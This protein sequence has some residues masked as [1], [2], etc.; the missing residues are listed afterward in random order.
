MPVPALF[1]IFIGRKSFPEAVKEAGPI[2]V[3]SVALVL[4]ASF[5]VGALSRGIAGVLSGDALQMKTLL[6]MHF[7]RTASSS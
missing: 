2:V 3:P 4:V 7:F 6:A 5:P 1:F